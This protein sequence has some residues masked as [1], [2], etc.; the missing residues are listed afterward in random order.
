MYKN[1]SDGE[2]EGRGID[3]IHS[4]MNEIREMEA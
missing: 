3:L 1:I 4:L 2:R